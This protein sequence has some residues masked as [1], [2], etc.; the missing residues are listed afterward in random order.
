[1][2]NA[3]DDSIQGY[4]NHKEPVY[5]LSIHPNNPDI[6]VSGGGDDKAHVW[7]M[8]DGENAIAILEGHTDSVTSVKFSHDGQF[9]ATGGMDGHIKIWSS[10]DWS[11]VTDFELSD[12]CTVSRSFCLKE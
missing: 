12:E 1:M 2:I 10:N 11:L 4:F 7:S 9:L 3:K 5:S 8:V 6:V